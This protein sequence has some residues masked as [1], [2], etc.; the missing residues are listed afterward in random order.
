ML[1]RA[2][3]Q[4]NEPELVVISGENEGSL[5]WK[6]TVVWAWMERT[7]QPKTLTQFAV[8]LP[9]LARCIDSLSIVT[10]LSPQGNFEQPGTLRKPH[11]VGFG[12]IR[13]SRR[14]SARQP[15]ARSCN[16]WVE[17]Q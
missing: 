8:I 15:V 17:A 12:N 14:Q 2:Q 5:V 9:A 10:R 1:F 3:V 11:S 7:K 16:V 4:M 13:D 6:R